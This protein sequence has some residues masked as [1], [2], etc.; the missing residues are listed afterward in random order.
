MKTV[1]ACGLSCP[2]PLLMLKNALKA[3]SE[4]VLLVSSPNAR[5]NCEEYAVKQ[6][7]TVKVSES[8]DVY[9]MEITKA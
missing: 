4:L 2:Q 9:T 6:G 3:E 7:C 5:Q 8:D 1:D